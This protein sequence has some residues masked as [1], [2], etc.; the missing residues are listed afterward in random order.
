MSSICL[1]VTVVSIKSASIVTVSEDV[2]A[3]QQR[4]SGTV[5][6]NA[7][8]DQV[9]YHSHQKAQRRQGMDIQNQCFW[10]SDGKA[11]IDNISTLL[12]F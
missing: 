9:I 6:R 12:H 1:L 4:K 3:L 7:K 8:L 2:V 5:N 11:L 10:R